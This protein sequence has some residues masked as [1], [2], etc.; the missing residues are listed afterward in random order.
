MVYGYD[1]RRLL[2][3]VSFLWVKIERRKFITFCHFLTLDN[4]K[5]LRNFKIPSII[6]ELE[7]KLEMETAIFILNEFFIFRLVRGTCSS[8]QHRLFD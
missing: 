3:S 7:E 1:S 2:L 8:N 5:Q 4:S 6:R